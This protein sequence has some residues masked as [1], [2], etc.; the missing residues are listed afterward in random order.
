MQDEHDTTTLPHVPF[1]DEAAS[2]GPV[3]DEPRPAWRGWI[4]LGAFPFAVAMGIVLIVLADSTAAKVGSAVFMATSL[5]MFGVSATYH[6]FPWGPTVK[7]VLKRID[8]TNIL[9]L[10]SG[11]YTPIAICAL[12]HGLMVG[13]L[14]VMWSGAAL[15]I[16]FRVLWV[17]APRW[18]YVPIYLVLG[19]AA[20]GLLPQF[21]AASVPM[22]V[23]VLSGGLA[24]VIGAVVYGFKRPD[25]APTVFGFHEVFHA[26][27]VVAFAAQW[28]G[29]LIVALDPV[30]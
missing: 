24:Y 22:T 23:L 7:R 12:P 19:C 6:R 8:H 28:A 21:F 16:A 5:A 13:V 26:L 11:T 30:R 10:I 29:V 9:L 1:T 17:D 2:A 25:P 18:L 3:A 14:W 27:T 4:H 20:L 15:G